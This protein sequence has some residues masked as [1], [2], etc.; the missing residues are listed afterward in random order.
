MASLLGNKLIEH[1]AVILVDLLHLVDVAGHL[2]HGFQGLCRH[3]RV[4]AG[5][6]RDRVGDSVFTLY[7]ETAKGYHLMFPRATNVTPKWRVSAR[8]VY[9]TAL[10]C[11]QPSYR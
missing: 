2:L 5:P 4:L 7:W 1:G 11:A 6:S 8:P 10:D 9:S 3:N